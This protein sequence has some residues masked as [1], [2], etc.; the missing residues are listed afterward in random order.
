MYR[1]YR[2]EGFFYTAFSIWMILESFCP[3][4]VQFLFTAALLAAGYPHPQNPR[5][6]TREGG[7][8]S[9]R[10]SPA[11]QSPPARRPSALPFAGKN[12]RKRKKRKRLTAQEEAPIRHRIG[13]PR[14]THRQ[15]ARQTP[16]DDRP[17]P[18][19]PPARLAEQP[20]AASATADSQHG[21]GQPPAR[22]AQR[23]A[24]PA[25]KNLLPMRMKSAAPA[26][27]VCQQRTAE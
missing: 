12:G 2:V 5:R 1:G 13:Q 27:R 26:E 17:A 10:P 7:A 20:A 25:E 22:Q 21:T 8:V 4:R 9:G 11:I 6:F 24:A 15:P 18:Q 16:T 3:L 23:T 19:P 14:R